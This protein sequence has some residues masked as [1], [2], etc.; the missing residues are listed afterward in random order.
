[1][2]KEKKRLLLF[3]SGNGTNAENII[4]YFSKKQSAEVVVVLSN[5]PHAGVLKKAQKQNVPTAVFSRTDFSETEKILSILASYH[6]DLIILAGFLWKIPP[7]VV[8]HYP[9][10]IINVHPAL[11]P[12]FGG[13]GMY[14]RHVHEAVIKS[15]ETKSGITIHYVNEK[16]DEGQIIFQKETEISPDETPESLAE[17]IHQLEYAY[18]PKVI[19]EIL[20]NQS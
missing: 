10:R 11:L 17:K 2:E 9:R 15:G 20:K 7:E 16:Y 8:R 12:R 18:F 6:P 4:R 1:M 19:E 3:A 5:N 14:G 13:K